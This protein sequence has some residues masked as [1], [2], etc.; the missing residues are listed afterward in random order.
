MLLIIGKWSGGVLGVGVGVNVG[1]PGVI[2]GVGLAVLVG[3]A[4]AVH[5]GPSVGLTVAVGVDVGAVVG[6]EVG[7][8]PPLVLQPIWLKM[9]RV[10]GPGS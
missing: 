8:V 7:V 3:V 5:V 4:V 6:V 1:P 10:I 2:V 9:P